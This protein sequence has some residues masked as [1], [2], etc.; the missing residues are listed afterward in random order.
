MRK[1]L[2]SYNIFL[3]LYLCADH[4]KSYEKKQFIVDITYLGTFL[5]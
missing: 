2:I 4:L 3:P 1:K 5:W